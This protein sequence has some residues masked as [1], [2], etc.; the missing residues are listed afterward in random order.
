MNSKAS[1]VS[2]KD[3]AAFARQAAA[4][5]TEENDDEGTPEWRAAMIE[6]I[7]ADRAAHGIPPLIEEW[8][9][10]QP[11]TDLYRRA[12]ALGLLRTVR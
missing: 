11:E 12:R 10:L 7:N 4:L 1:R 6:R 5:A 8:W 3:R 9:N 2:D